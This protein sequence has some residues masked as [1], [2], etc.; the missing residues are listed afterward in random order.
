MDIWVVSIFLLLRRRLLWMFHVQVLCGHVLLGMYLKGEL[1][2]HPVTPSS[3]LCISMFRTQIQCYFQC[4]TTSLSE[5]SFSLALHCVVPP[6]CAQSSAIPTWLFSSYCELLESRDKHSAFC[7]AQHIEHTA[8][9]TAG[10]LLRA[11]EW[12]ESVNFTWSNLQNISN[13]KCPF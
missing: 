11:F 13:S 1:L 9:H 2:G 3:L 12:V 8:L 5:R 10:T 7:T 6:Y 4:S